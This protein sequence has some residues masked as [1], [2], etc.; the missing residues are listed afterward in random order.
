MYFREDGKFSNFKLC[1][2]CKFHF[3]GSDVCQISEEE[4]A[5]L[6]K[7]DKREELEKLKRCVFVYCFILFIMGGA[8]LKRFD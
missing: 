3:C 8:G 4:V 1:F 6:F 5:E 2:V 7:E